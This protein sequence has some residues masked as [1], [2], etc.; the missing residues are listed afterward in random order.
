MQSYPVVRIGGT[1]KVT[2]MTDAEYQRCS[3]VETLELLDT[4]TLAVRSVPVVCGGGADPRD[5]LKDAAWFNPSH[6]LEWFAGSYWRGPQVC[7]MALAVS[8]DASEAGGD[9]YRLPITWGS[10]AKH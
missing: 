4:S 1:A 9:G 6:H 5:K 8:P 3:Q 7:R 2:I 10:S